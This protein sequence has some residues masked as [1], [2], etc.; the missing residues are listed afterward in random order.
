MILTIS[1]SF[2]QESA[3]VKSVSDLT[4]IKESGKGSITLPSKLTKEEVAS[5]AKYYNLYFTVDFD[6]K[7]KLATINMVDNSERSRM[8]IVR[9]LAGC[10]VQTINVAGD[11]VNRDQLFDKY[12]K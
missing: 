2:S 3:S 4:S 5:K 7:S 8:I 6:E 9:F 11:I 12:L 1:F 10:E